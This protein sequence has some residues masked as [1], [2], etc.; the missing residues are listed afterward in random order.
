MSANSPPAQG[1]PRQAK[2][3]ICG[4]P[5]IW[6]GNDHGTTVR[7]RV[8]ANCDAPSGSTLAAHMGLGS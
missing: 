6:V 1:K 4:A 2:C 7:T 5:K 3:G 8:C